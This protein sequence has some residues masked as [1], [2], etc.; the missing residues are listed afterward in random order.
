MRID[1]QEEHLMVESESDMMKNFKIKKLGT[2]FDEM[3][4]SV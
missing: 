3:F 1:D 4:D 2:L